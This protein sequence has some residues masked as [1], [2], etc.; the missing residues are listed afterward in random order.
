MVTAG[1]SGVVGSEDDERCTCNEREEH[2]QVDSSQAP[3]FARAAAWLLLDGGRFCSFELRAD[4][5]I[6]W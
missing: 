5:R 3:W 6:V 2:D 4:T 1:V